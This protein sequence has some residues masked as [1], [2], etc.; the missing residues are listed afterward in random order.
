MSL[1][2]LQLYAYYASQS[3]GQL[4]HQ[5]DLFLALSSKLRLQ[6]SC[7]NRQELTHALYAIPCGGHQDMNVVTAVQNEGESLAETYIPQ[8]LV[9]SQPS[10]ECERWL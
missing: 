10:G 7:S 5:A 9:A 6:T 8:M 1:G 3:S 4:R 2:C